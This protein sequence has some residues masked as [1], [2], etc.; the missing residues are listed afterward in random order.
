MKL[1]KSEFLEKVSDSKISIVEGTPNP[2]TRNGLYV[3]STKGLM[4]RTFF[5]SLDMT[6][7]DMIY[8]SV[9]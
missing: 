5:V 9:G 2:E 8:E 1:T 3:V 7:G 6:C 4:V